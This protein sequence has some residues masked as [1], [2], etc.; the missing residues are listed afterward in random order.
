V[1]QVKDYPAGHAIGYNR[2]FVTAAATRAALLPVGYADGFKRG[3]SNRANVLLH[4]RRCRVLGMVSMDCTVV[5]VTAAPDAAVGDL[6]TLV[7]ADGPE[8][9]TVEDLVNLMP[10]TIPYELLT[11]LG[12]R[13]HWVYRNQESDAR[14]A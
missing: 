10:G 3:L 1:V 13:N 4:G 7:G 2:T 5:D 12:T 8:R 14:A 9:I 11:S 6:V